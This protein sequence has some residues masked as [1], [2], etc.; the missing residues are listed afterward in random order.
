MTEWHKKECL[1]LHCGN[2]W[3]G[4][5]PDDTLL[6]CPKCKEMMGKARDQLDI[7]E[8]AQYLCWQVEGLPAGEQQTKCSIIASALKTLLQPPQS[9]FA[10][11]PFRQVET[12]VRWRRIDMSNP[13]EGRV[14]LLSTSKMVIIG[15]WYKG[16]WRTNESFWD[17]GELKS[18]YM[19]SDMTH[20][21]PIP[22][23]PST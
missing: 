19:L 6:E 2:E 1:C 5:I 20:W 23:A 11:S 16:M 22:D 10:L 13:P 21:T 9:N 17:K 4:M 8:I 3:T 15:D 14:L 12:L 7:A 18:I